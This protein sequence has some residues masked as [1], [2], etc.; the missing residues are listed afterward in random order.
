MTCPPQQST[1]PESSRRRK[2]NDIG[3]V[4]ADAIRI[5]GRQGP[6]RELGVRADEEIR[7]RDQRCGRS[8]LL[9]APGAVPAIGGGTSLRGARGKVD[10]LHAPRPYLAG[11]QLRL[12]GADTD[13][14]DADGIRRG[15]VPNHAVGD[16][17]DCLCMEG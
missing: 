2:E 12:R 16:R 15:S 6:P 5:R 8:R 4:G 1:M 7:Q 3:E 13:L 17:R 14:G 9:P 11:Y 10:N